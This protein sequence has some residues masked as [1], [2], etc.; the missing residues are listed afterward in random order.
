MAKTP[1][2]VSF[3]LDETG[4]ME[5][6]RTE[7]IDGFNDYIKELKKEKNV[8]FT[9][10]TFDS[11]KTDIRYEAVPVKDVKKL[12]RDTYVPGQMTPLYDATVTAI[13]AMGKKKK[14]LFV[15]M[16]DGLENASKE[17]SQKDAFDL[18]EKK[19]KAGWTFLFLGA[20]QDAYIAGGALGIA[21]GN[22]ASF[23]QKKTGETFI[24]VASASKS[25]ARSGGEQ[26]SQYLDDLD[27]QSW[28]DDDRT[29]K[30]SQ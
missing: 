25:Y 1:V 12:N 19:K 15:I 2:N 22:T 20:N 16:T 6:V 14:V 11:Q 3:L 4:S 29:S 24:A 23:N 5:A 7:T 10:T 21:V 30:S 17:F 26:S 9:L 28:R 18:I 13:K 27:D 8:R